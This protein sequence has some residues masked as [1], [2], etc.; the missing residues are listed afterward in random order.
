MEEWILGDL[1]QRKI[2]YGIVQPGEHIKNGVPV[3]KVNNLVSGLRNVS[4]L[5]TISIDIDNKYNRTRLL[6]GELI[7]SVVG[8]IGRTAIVP[9]NFT[10]CNLVRAIALIDP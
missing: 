3:V 5:A 7:I 6:G 2:G 10:G 8:T 9:P 4:D 1:T